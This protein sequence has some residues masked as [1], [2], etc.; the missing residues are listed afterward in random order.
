MFT[1]RHSSSPKVPQSKSLCPPQKNAQFFFPA[2]PP[3]H[4][5]RRYS[6][7]LRSPPAASDPGQNLKYA[8]SAEFTTKPPSALMRL[9]VLSALEASSVRSRLFTS[10]GNRPKQYAAKTTL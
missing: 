7:A 9:S 8:R 2:F 10:S 1:P 5:T 6:T 4:A 3:Q